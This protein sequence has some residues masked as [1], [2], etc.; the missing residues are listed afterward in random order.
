MSRE[1]VD[2]SKCLNLGSNVCPMSHGELLENVIRYQCPLYT[3]ESS[4][5]ILKDLVVL[6]DDRYATSYDTGYGICIKD[7][8]MYK[9][10]SK[11]Q[12][13]A[14]KD[15]LEVIVQE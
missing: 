10:I 8:Y 3:K 7:T 6:V 9:S 1:L 14:L 5:D 4:L 13:D 12:F 2:C 11:E 15:I